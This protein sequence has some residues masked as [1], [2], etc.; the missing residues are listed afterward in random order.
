[1]STGTVISENPMI[2]CRTL[3]KGAITAYFDVFGL[4]R[5]WS[6]RSSNSQY[7]D[8]EAKAPDNEAKSPDNEARALPLGHF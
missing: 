3:G 1:M 4:M 2:F 6:K 5:P 8:N 7:P